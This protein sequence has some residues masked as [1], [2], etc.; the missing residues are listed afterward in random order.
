MQTRK[1][2][3]FWVLHKNKNCAFPLNF[4]K[5]CVICEEYGV[6]Y[7]FINSLYCILSQGYWRQEKVLKRYISYWI[8]ASM[9]KT[10]EE[11]FRVPLMHSPP[12][13]VEISVYLQI[14][15]N[16]LLYNNIFQKHKHLHNTGLAWTSNSSSCIVICFEFS[17]NDSI[18]FVFGLLRNEWYSPAAINFSL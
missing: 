13:A 12:A 10:P 2:S 8:S 5:K 9:H 14:T 1:A 15:Y 17:V 7:Q 11:L 18:W 6:L 4:L 16:M 3:D